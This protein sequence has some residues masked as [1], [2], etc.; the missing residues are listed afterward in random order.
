MEGFAKGIPAKLPK[1][2]MKGV[3]RKDESLAR[4]SGGVNCLIGVEE[5]LEFLGDIMVLDSLSVLVLAD[6][7]LS[8]LC[9]DTVSLEG[10][11][12]LFLEACLVLWEEPSGVE[13]TDL[14]CEYRLGLGVEGIRESGWPGKP[15]WY[16]DERSGLLPYRPFRPGVGKI[17]EVIKI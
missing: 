5:M 9:W 15:V 2:N 1:G 13:L 14:W 8:D 6:L 4:L 3:D 12:E 11:G 16:M 17:F 7:T 10:T